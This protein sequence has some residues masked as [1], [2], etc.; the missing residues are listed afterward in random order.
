MTAKTRTPIQKLPSLM[1]GFRLR[2]LRLLLDPQRALQ[3]ILSTAARATRADAGSFVLINPNTGLLDIEASIGLSLRAKKIKLRPGEGITGWVASTGKPMRISDVQLE[4]KYIAANPRVRSELAVPVEIRGGIVG[5][6]NVDSTQVDAFTE[7]DETQ[8]LNFAEQ[9]AKWLE[10]AWKIDQ[11]RVKDQ[12]LSS[13]LNMGRMIISETNLD[14]AL[15]Q[16]TRQANRLMHTKLCSL[17]LVGGKNEEELTLLAS[18]GGSENYQSRPPLPVGESLLGVVVTRRKPLTVLN[19]REHHRYRHLEV[20][21][22]EGLVSLLAVPLIFNDHLL[23]VLAV[24]TRHL[25]RFSNDEIKL[26]TA[27][28]DLSAVAIEKGRLLN[29]IVDMEEKLRASERLSALGLLAA[30]IAHEIRNPLTV[31]QMLFHALIESLS[32]DEASARDAQVISE[33]MRQMNRIV[34]QVLGFARSSEP[35]KESIS[36]ST[37]VDDI[38]LLIR[39]KLNAAG[40]EVRHHIDPNL[41]TFKADRAQIEQA[42]LN[43]ILNAADAMPRD[44]NGVLRLSATREEMSG[45]DYLVLGVRD[46]GQGMTEEQLEN[47]FAPFLTYKKQ[48]TGIG[49][50]IVRKIVEN[51]QGKVQVDS[52]PGRGTQFRLYFPL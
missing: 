27:L 29:R 40:I 16:I 33:K 3:R 28:A 41:P 2:D 11:M 48:G 5:V 36:A 43:L 7:N 9:A 46:N 13:L 34:D 22:K 25:H 44:G 38:I 20:A 1:E 31:M 39:H 21:Q 51:H 4:P 15:H 42:L 10:L 19:V 37:L 50:A 24:Y 26:L 45:T 17:L 30:E 35:T 18:H 23:G 47:I 12:Q 14:Q 32:L 6:L 52:K 8:L 49:L